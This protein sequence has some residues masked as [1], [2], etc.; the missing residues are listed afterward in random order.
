MDNE[1]E[2]ST[3]GA[4]FSLRGLVLA[5]TN[6]RKLKHA[7]RTSSLDFSAALAAKSV[8]GSGIHDLLFE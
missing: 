5:R 6:T 1:V 4:R 3:S 2:S 7:P 8:H